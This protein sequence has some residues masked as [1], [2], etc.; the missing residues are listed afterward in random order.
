MFISRVGELTHGLSPCA[1][2]RR[3]LI[4]GPIVHIPNRTDQGCLGSGWWPVVLG[5][6]G[7]PKW[8][9]PKRGGHIPSGINPGGLR[10]PGGSGKG[11]PKGR[12]LDPRWE[13]GLGCDESPQQPETPINLLQILVISSACSQ[14]DSGWVPLATF[15][16]VM[17][18]QARPKC[19]L[20]SGITR[21]SVS[22]TITWRHWS[23]KV[24]FDL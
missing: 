21:Y 4:G 14:L 24:S 2:L 9:G 10:I 17:P 23:E 8:N 1:H 13:R 3:E 5:I 7:P 22:R 15:S 6:G 19:L 16:V 11:E 18:L 20:S 12:K